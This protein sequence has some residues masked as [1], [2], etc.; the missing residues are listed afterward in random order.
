MGNG[1]VR[2]FYL[3]ETYSIMITVIVHF[4]TF[5]TLLSSTG[6]AYPSY[7]CY[8]ATLFFFKK[9]LCYIIWSLVLGTQFFFLSG[10]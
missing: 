2:R 8:Q 10:G 5:D 9:N 6:I 1:N 4:S 3:G 7:L